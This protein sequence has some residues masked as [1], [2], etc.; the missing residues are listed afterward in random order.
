MTSIFQNTKISIR[1][2]RLVV[3]PKDKRFIADIL[4]LRRQIKEQIQLKKPD[5]NLNE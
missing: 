4:L 5:D 2:S 3:L 1:L